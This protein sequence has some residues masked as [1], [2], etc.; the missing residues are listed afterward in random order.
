MTTTTARC[1]AGR[2]RPGRA[3]DHRP[4]RRD[5]RHGSLA[6]VTGDEVFRAHEGGKLITASKI[7]LD[8]V[9]DLSIAYTPGVAL[10]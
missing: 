6:A 3:R 1:P 10:V 2:R 8:S 4:G 9:R 7:G 5:Q